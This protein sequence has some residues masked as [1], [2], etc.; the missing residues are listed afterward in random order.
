MREEVG[1][2]PK[3]RTYQV[4]REQLTAAE[5]DHLSNRLFPL[6]RELKNKAR[7]NLA[8]REGRDERG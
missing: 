2:M 4:A 3:K 8:R 7:A 5:W 6:M 1:I